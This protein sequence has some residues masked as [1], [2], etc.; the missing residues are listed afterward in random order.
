MSL[1]NNS[2]PLGATQYT[3]DSMSRLATVSDG[4]HTATYTRAT[5]SN[6]LTNASI[7]DGTNTVL[8]RG[9]VY[10]NLNR[11]TSIT[12]SVPSVPSVV[13]SY[14]YT[15]ND[16]D[17]RTKITFADGS[18]WDYTYDDK[19]QV[20]SA[21]RTPAAGSTMPL[22]ATQFGYSFDDIGNRIYA[23]MGMP[24][25]R[26]NYTSN[27]LNQYTQMTVPGIIPVTGK[28]ATDAKV[29]VTK[30]SDS[31]VHATT[32]DGKYF[33]AAVPADNTSAKV[34]ENLTINAVRF[35]ATQD[36]DVVATTTR[37]GTADKTPQTFT[38]DDDG[39]MLTNG[40]WTYTWNAENRLIEAVKT[41]DTKLEFMYD[42]M[43]RRIDKKVYTYSPS[44][45][46]FQLSTHQKFVYDGYL[47][48]AE[49]D[50]SNAIQKSY[51]WAGSS[52]M[53]WQKDHINSK[54]H[55]SMYDGNKNIV[56][57]VDNTGTLT[58][59]YEYS[60]F[61]KILSKSGT[62]ADSNKFRFSSE[63]HDDETG[64]VYYNYRYY[65][66]ELGRWIKRDPVGEVDNS[67]YIYIAN[68]SISNTDILGLQPFWKKKSKNIY[69]AVVDGATLKQLAKMITGDESD[70]PCIW[71]KGKK[72]W[73]NYPAATE[74][75]KADVSNLLAKRDARKL[76]KNNDIYMVAKEDDE[77]IESVKKLFHAP[78]PWTSGKDAA[79]HIQKN[80]GEGKKPITRLYIGGHHHYGAKKISGFQASDL[81][82]V[83]SHKNQIKNNAENSRKKI[84]PPKC[85]FTRDSEVWGFGC[86]TERGWMDDWAKTVMRKGSTIYGVKGPDL[87][88]GNGRKMLFR[89][90]KK[91]KRDTIITNS[92]IRSILKPEV[93]K[94]GWKNTHGLN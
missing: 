71:I 10:D 16:K 44:T 20:V 80:S 17:Q 21:V 32:R 65:D 78:K 60:P 86:I 3:Y 4:T 50:I 7:S 68:D 55:Y 91:N 37:T 15:Y 66:P 73:K 46:N 54:Y 72:K 85:W 81:I 61:G 22:G 41:N 77:F 74:C 40:D 48:I 49:F 42:Y 33:K 63:H 25:M 92:V 28:A 31:S 94:L 87:I 47:Q 90:E 93:L 38:Y 6:L 58:S 53:E 69:E 13:K 56:G 79:E 51:T 29:T 67:L 83:A 30:G 18:Y 34:T 26:Y 5:G 45:F 59:S 8:N 14:S 84:G 39:N 75:A 62:Y 12:N 11:L 19:G 1:M 36:K 27:A 52:T 23:D 24:Q 2:T 9:R 82:A 35:D 57:T 70:S 64:L 76:G 43:G 88:Y 89:Q